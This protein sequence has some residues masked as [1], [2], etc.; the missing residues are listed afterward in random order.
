VIDNLLSNAIKYGRSKPIEITIEALD[1]RAQLSVRDWG[2]GIPMEEQ[3]RIFER[4]ERAVSGRAYTGLGLGLWIVRQ[5][6]DAMGGTIEVRSSPG[7]GS[8]F[9]ISLPLAIARDRSPELGAGQLR[10]PSA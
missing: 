8:T 6:L 2:I 9:L 3:A 1:N 4:F 10:A 5:I 7:E